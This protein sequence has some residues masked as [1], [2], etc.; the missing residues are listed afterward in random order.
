MQRAERYS[1]NKKKKLNYNI[2]CLS[3]LSFPSKT[4]IKDEFLNL[5]FFEDETS[6]KNTH[7]DAYSINIEL[8]VYSLRVHNSGIVAA[9]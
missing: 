4:K 5:I 8:F 2:F 3:R 7:L 9:S 1:I 6:N